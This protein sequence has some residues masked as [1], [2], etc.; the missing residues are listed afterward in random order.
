MTGEEIYTIIFLV[1]L[2]AFAAIIFITGVVW[3]F[4]KVVTIGINLL[5]DAWFEM[6]VA[7]RDVLHR[8]KIPVEVDEE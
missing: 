8:A 6:E 4:F 5:G 1:V 7:W 2:I 3:A